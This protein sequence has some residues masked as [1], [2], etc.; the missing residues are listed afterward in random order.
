[1]KKILAVMALALATVGLTACETNG[2]LG[3]GLPN[4]GSSQNVS[5]PTNLSEFLS[6]LDQENTNYVLESDMMGYDTIYTFDGN[7]TKIEMKVDSESLIIYFNYEN[8]AL[9]AYQYDEATSTWSSSVDDGTGMMLI[10]FGTMIDSAGLKAS[11]F[12]E[13]KTN[14][15]TTTVVDDDV[16]ATVKI[17]INADGSFTYELTSDGAT[18]TMKFSS[19]GSASVTLP[20]VS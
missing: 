10:M 9:M 17:T 8:D 6:W 18:A 3:G 13:D 19:F 20:T 1:M 14:E 15:Y 5:T 2:Y 16:E 4:I 12:T 7:K 11:D